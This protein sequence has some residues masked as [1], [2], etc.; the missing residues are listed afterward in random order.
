ML[1]VSAVRNDAR[2][3][4]VD[5]A[6]FSAALTASSKQVSPMHLIHGMMDHAPR[7][8]MRQ[9]HFHLFEVS[10]S[11]CDMAALPTSEWQITKNKILFEHATERASYPACQTFTDQFGQVIVLVTVLVF[12]V[13]SSDNSGGCESSSCDYN[14]CENGRL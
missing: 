12:S 8:T 1:T 3:H 11:L 6:V 4:A 7:K 2:S 13:N 5:C 9:W 14:G 10:C